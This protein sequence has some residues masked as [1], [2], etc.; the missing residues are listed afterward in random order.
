MFYAIACEAERRF[1]LEPLPGG[2]L[3]LGRG[4]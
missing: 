2:V 3:I 1:K 4:R